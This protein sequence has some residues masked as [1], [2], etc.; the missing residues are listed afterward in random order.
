MAA[1]APAKE[2]KKT[3]E[4]S[5]FM[6]EFQKRKKAVLAR[7]G[8][9]TEEAEAPKESLEVRLARAIQAITEN[10][11]EDDETGDTDVM[12]GDIKGVVDEDLAKQMRRMG[13]LDFVGSSLNDDT[14]L[15]L[16]KL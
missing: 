3:E 6:S 5:E 16:K 4:E 10:G 7:S 14:I 1:P 8:R 11:V 12:F 15:T 13:Q 9:K 2:E